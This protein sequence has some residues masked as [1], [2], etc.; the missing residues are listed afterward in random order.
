MFS[1]QREM[2]V[3]TDVCWP[4]SNTVTVRRFTMA[5]SPF[6]SLQIQPGL[7]SGV[8]LYTVDAVTP[9]PHDRLTLIWPF[10]IDAL[11]LIVQ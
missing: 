10:P 7:R 5:V 2:L 4:P 9:L 1:L 8:H 11:F 6:S 3:A